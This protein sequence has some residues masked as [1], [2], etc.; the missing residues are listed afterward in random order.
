MNSKGLD[1]SPAAT[2]SRTATKPSDPRILQL[3]PISSLYRALVVGQGA[4]S[5]G[6]PERFAFE[7]RTRP[8][9]AS[10]PGAAIFSTITSRTPR[11]PRLRNNTSAP[12]RSA[13]A[14][15]AKALQW[16][17]RLIETGMEKKALA[18]PWNTDGA[19]APAGSG[20]LHAAKPSDGR[21]SRLA[22]ARNTESN[23]RKAMGIVKPCQPPL[24]RDRFWRQSRARGAI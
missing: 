1:L 13:L 12:A 20:R 14:G 18:P 3:A 7:R 17:R 10:A 4:I 21:E 24:T 23:G 9:T 19:D 16:R 6:A 5:D 15:P 11:V 22:R 8:P 2:A